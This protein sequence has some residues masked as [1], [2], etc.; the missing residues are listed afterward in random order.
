MTN[1]LNDLTNQPR[2]LDNVDDDDDDGDDDE[3]YFYSVCS[4]HRQ[5]FGGPLKIVWEVSRSIRSN[6][7]MLNMVPRGQTIQHNT[8]I[9]GLHIFYLFGHLF[10]NRFATILGIVVR[11][12]PWM[13]KG[14]M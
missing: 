3:D 13:P 14:R 9:C 2:T 5:G 1:S 8:I 7:A 4:A 11:D 12:S 10:S 6:F